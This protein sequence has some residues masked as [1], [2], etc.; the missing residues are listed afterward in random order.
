[1]IILVIKLVYQENQA[2]EKKIIET[3]KIQKEIEKNQSEKQI[4]LKFLQDNEKALSLI[5]A[6]SKILEE[7][8]LLDKNK[9]ELEILTIQKG[10]TV[11]SETVAGI[12]I[13]SDFLIFIVDTSGSM[14]VI[15]DEVQQ[16]I[17][18]VLESYP[19]I[20]GIQVMDADG[21]LLFPY[22]GYV[23]MRADV[24]GLEKIKKAVKNWEKQSSSSPE[25]GIKT[26]IENF[27]ARDKKIA[28]WIFADDYQGRN[29]VDNLIRFVD[30]INTV[31]RSG[32][33]L[34]TINALGFRT[35]FAP[36]RQKFALAMRELC[37][38]NGGAFI[39]L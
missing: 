10:E 19:S 33:R 9:A 13:D 20:K 7:Q 36:G 31:K 32:K 26:A 23:W 2:L 27:Y 14:K 11:V 18:A 37:E 3:D 29:S 30:S 22:Q 4:R 28:L 24:N 34:V 1:M 12:K 35:D 8:I 6:E 15:W 21:S 16:K 25:E 5:R 17:A 39:G 38:R